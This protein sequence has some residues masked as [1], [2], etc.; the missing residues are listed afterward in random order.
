M[1]ATI[2]RHERIRTQRPLLMIVGIAVVLI[3]LADLLALFF[4]ILGLIFATMLTL[5]LLPVVQFYLVIDFYRSSYGNGAMLTHVLPVTGRKLFWTKSL[6]ALVLSLLVGF[7]VAIILFA[8]ARLALTV[9]D[10]GMPEVARDLQLLFHYVQGLWPV[11]I[12]SVIWVLILPIAAM[13]ASVV[14]G[15]GG[16][17]RRLS[18]A[19][20]IIVFMSY[21]LL[22]QILGFASFF[23]PPVFDIAEGQLRFESFWSLVMI[24]ETDPVLPVSIFILH[25]LVIG[26]MLFWASRDMHSKVELR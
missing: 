19:G 14:I 4:G 20:P 6:Y 26:A 12:G 25:L 9:V 1:T 22:M 7:L 23:V 11:L 10:I 16:W 13:Y 15:S 18:I 5:A 17:A 2:L 3:A 24:N 8:Q 21:Y